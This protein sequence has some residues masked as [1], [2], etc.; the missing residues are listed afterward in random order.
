MANSRLIHCVC[1][2]TLAR[3]LGTHGTEAQT[4]LVR[5]RSKSACQGCSQNKVKCS[6]GIPCARCLSTGRSCLR[7]SD[8]SNGRLSCSKNLLGNNRDTV[9][10]LPAAL[11]DH[12]VQM[13][14]SIT[15]FPSNVT[16]FHLT[17]NNGQC[18]PNGPAA[19]IP[20]ENLPL[21]T[22][23]MG[24]EFPWTLEYT[25]FFPEDHLIDHSTAELGASL[26]CLPFPFTPSTE[27][28]PN[29]SLAIPNSRGPT[30]AEES[31]SLGRSSANWQQE[32]RHSE[33]S[34]P[35]HISTM[36]ATDDDITVAENFCHVMTR[37][38]DAYQAILTFHAQQSD[39]RFTSLSFPHFSVFNSFIQLYYEH[40]DNQLSFIHPSLLEKKD[41]PWMLALAVASIGCQYTELAKREKYV[42]MLTELSRL[43]IPLDVC[44]DRYL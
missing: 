17:T 31:R 24:S 44:Y 6:G 8:F 9:S 7:R 4:L 10:G 40:F 12:A 15:Q 1:R 32:L 20:V 27:L 37:L 13:P 2:D 43:S 22:L 39:I 34:A 42:S 19:S 16:N 36:Q 11:T 28:N 30:P 35:I 41:T 33:T 29:S 18:S 14:S 3:H 38:D 21:L 25:D 23:D 26:E 5:T